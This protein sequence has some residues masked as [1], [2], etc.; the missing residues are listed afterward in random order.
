M[1]AFET[2]N[3]VRKEE[4]AKE[5][6]RVIRSGLLSGEQKAI[7]YYD[8]VASERDK[9]VLDYFN[10]KDSI[11][12]AADCL[13]RIADYKGTLPKRNVLQNANLSDAEKEYICL[14]KIVQK[15]NIEKEKA[16]IAALRQAGVGMNDYL[17][18]K[19]KFSQVDDSGAKTEVKAAE[20][21]QWLRDEGYTWQQRTV[22]GEV[23]PFWSQRKKEYR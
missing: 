12:E 6:R 5:Q 18:I 1:L 23:F 10:G 19:N 9:E 16:R 4:K 21:S 3:K 11:A 8:L 2:I 15:D 14:N 17:K 7:L 20:M 22:I 13:S